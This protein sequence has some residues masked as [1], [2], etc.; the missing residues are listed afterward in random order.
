MVNSNLG[1]LHKS[2]T[3]LIEQF[4]F[5][6]NVRYDDGVDSFSQSLDYWPALMSEAEML[7]HVKVER[8][9]VEKNIGVLPLYK[10]V[11]PEKAYWDEMEFLSQLNATGYRQK[12]KV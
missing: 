2:Q 11:D 8:D 4:E 12:M 7:E 1:W 6:P 9:Y 10:S 5:H 3:E